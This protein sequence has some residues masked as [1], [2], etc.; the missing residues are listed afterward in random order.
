[1]EL[2]DASLEKLCKYVYDT[3]LQRIPEHI[4]GKI[5]VAVSNYNENITYKVPSIWKNQI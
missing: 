1:M 2:M 3:I 4:L 5:A